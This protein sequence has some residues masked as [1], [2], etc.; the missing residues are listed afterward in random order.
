LV[1][2]WGIIE[3]EI[4]GKCDLKEEVE[5]PRQGYNYGKRQDI[6]IEEIG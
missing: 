1:G 4:T 6:N 5:K 3:R 2:C